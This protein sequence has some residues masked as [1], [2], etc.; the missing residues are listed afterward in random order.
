[1]CLEVSACS[2]R[3]SMSRRAKDAPEGHGAEGGRLVCLDVSMRQFLLFRVFQA[4]MGVHTHAR[5]YVVEFRQ[6]QR[7]GVQLALKIRHVAHHDDVVFALEFVAPRQRLFLPLQQDRVE[8]GLQFVA[9]SLAQFFDAFG[10]REG[11]SDL[12]GALEM[13]LEV[14][15]VGKTLPRCLGEDQQC[16]ELL[17]GL[18]GGR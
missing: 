9:A 11:P 14:P 8:D 10:R 5:T 12:D 16:V 6:L 17:G 3:D 4:G 18:I 2:A 15:P 13:A 1:M 7:G